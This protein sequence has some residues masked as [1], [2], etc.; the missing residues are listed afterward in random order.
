VKYVGLGPWIFIDMYY[1]WMLL[2]PE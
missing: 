1:L 2:L